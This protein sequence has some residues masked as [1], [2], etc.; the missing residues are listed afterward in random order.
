MMSIRLRKLRS[1]HVGTIDNIGAEDRITAR[2]HRRRARTVH[3]STYR[4]VVLD[5]DTKPQKLATVLSNPLMRLE[6]LLC[7]YVRG[8]RAAPEFLIPKEP[9]DPHLVRTRQDLQTAKGGTLEQERQVVKCSDASS[10]VG[11]VKSS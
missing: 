5:H 3:E 7:V 2:R 1:F 10:R 11:R 9:R 6:R 8:S 4:A